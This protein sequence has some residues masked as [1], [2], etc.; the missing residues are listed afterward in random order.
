M[1]NGGKDEVLA[2]KMGHP[3]SFPFLGL[4]SFWKLSGPL[5]LL[6]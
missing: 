4:V 2:L 3:V 5:S 6:P 1:G